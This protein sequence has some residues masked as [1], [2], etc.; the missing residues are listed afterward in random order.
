ML[1]KTVCI[2]PF[3]FTHKLLGVN[4]YVYVHVHVYVCAYVN[5]H[6]NV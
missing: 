3:M 5:M 6:V 2:Y 1:S 4:V